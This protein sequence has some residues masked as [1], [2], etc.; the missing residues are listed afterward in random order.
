MDN[1]N[2]RFEVI[3]GR[4]SD[5]TLWLQFIFGIQVLIVGGLIV[6]WLLMRKRTIGTE[7]VVEIHLAE[8][9]EKQLISIQREEIDLLK[10][11]LGRL[12]PALA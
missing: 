2:G 3:D 11:R 10:E 4:F 7:K 9:E 6:Q 5:L 1:M 8:K 12:E